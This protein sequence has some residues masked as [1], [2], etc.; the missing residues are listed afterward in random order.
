LPHLRCVIAA[1]NSASGRHNVEE[2]D[3]ALVDRF[4][5][6]IRLA[7]PPDRAWFVETFGAKMGNALVDYYETDLDA[8]QQAMISNRRLEYLGRCAQSG[9]ALR[10]GLPPEVKLP[11]HLLQARLEAQ[12][13]LDIADFVGDPDKFSVLVARQLDVALR[14][15]QLLPRMRPEQTS[16]VKDVILALPTEVLTQIQTESPFVFKKASAAIV[17]F[18]GQGDADAFEQLLQERLP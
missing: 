6:H 18:D 14:F 12:P 8:K 7:A 15:A 17:K 2:L 4:H 10:H 13:V 11:L 5:V 9:I 3:P 16:R 1:I